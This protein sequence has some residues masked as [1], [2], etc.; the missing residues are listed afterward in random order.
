MAA[1]LLFA[2]VA[3]VGSRKASADAGR[4]TKPPPDNQQGFD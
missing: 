3:C 2:D 1:V 4:L